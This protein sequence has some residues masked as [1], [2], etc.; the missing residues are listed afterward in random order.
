MAFVGDIV[1]RARTNTAFRQVVATGP[2]AQVVV[3]SVTPNTDIGLETHVELDQILVVVAGEGA[4]IL[5]TEQ[6]HI[7]PGSLVLVPAG[8]QHNI[9]NTGPVDLRLYTVYAPPGHAPGTVHL[10]KG[11]AERDEAD[12]MPVEAT[13]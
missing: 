11:D 5:D 6:R 1:E 7:R 9:V 10:T 13:T 3:M 12:R 8:T 2:H 4:A